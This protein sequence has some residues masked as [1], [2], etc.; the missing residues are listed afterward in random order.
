LK[1]WCATSAKRIQVKANWNSGLGPK[2]QQAPEICRGIVLVI[3][4]TESG[5][6]RSLDF[7]ESP[8]RWV[9]LLPDLG[10]SAAKA[11]QI[12]SFGNC[13]PEQ[14]PKPEKQKG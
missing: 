5:V 2:W 14:N 6:D 10:S 4:L 9:S 1:W 8:F 13:Y 3:T 7:H 11:Q 12:P